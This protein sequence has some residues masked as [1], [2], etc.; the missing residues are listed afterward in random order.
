MLQPNFEKCGGII[1]VIAQDYLTKDVLMLAYMNKEAF[2]KTLETNQAHYYSRSRQK[3]WHKGSESGHFQNV[4]QIL[5]DCDEDT[6]VLLIE[7]IGGA[8]CHTGYNSCFYREIHADKE[9]TICSD[10]IF[11]PDEV[12][13]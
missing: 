12:Y 2:E 8:A 5:I 6:I 1:P 4:K 3:L 11:N 10:K 7:Q 13:K 9:P